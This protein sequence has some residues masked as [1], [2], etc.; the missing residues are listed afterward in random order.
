MRRCVRTVLLPPS[1][2]RASSV[3]G[4]SVA[5]REVALSAA[6]GVSVQPVALSFTHE[7]REAQ[8]LLWSVIIGVSVQLVPLATKAVVLCLQLLHAQLGSLATETVIVSLQFLHALVLGLSRGSRLSSHGR[9]QLW[10][11]RERW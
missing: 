7:S 10:S 6:G 8:P 3:V 9:P 2:E 4:W 5:I 1:H 11:R